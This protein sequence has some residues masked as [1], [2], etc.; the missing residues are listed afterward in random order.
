MGIAALLL[1]FKI[2][3]A[4]S[5]GKREVMAPAMNVAQDAVTLRN[6]WNNGEPPVIDFKK[7]TV[8]FLYAGEK[9]TGGFTIK[10]KSVKKRGKETII[11][12]PIEGPPPGGMVTQAITHPFT[13][14][15][16]PKSTH[17]KWQIGR[18]SCRER[19]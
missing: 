3:Q 1:T 8:V 14:I 12:A 5:Y 4:G 7:Q 11:D 18:A 9:T 19:G 13:V 16:I 6:L 15:A 2:L 17:E 10:V